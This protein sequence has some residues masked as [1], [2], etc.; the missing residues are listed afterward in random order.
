[1]TTDSLL[2][3]A[4]TREIETLRTGV[5]EK[6]AANAAVSAPVPGLGPA[7][8]RVYRSDHGVSMLEGPHQQPAGGADERLALPVLDV[9]GLLADQRHPGVRGAGGEDRL[10]GRLPQV[11]APAGG[12]GSPQAVEVCAFRKLRAGKVRHSAPECQA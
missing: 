1:M 7:A 11:A 12:R 9:P 3:D 4:L 8:S 2:I 5:P 6:N 10:R